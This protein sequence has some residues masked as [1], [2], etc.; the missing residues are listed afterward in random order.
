M[1]EG[2]WE[3]KG[4]REWD[5]GAGERVYEEMV[6]GNGMHKWRDDEGGVKRRRWLEEWEKLAENGKVREEGRLIVGVGYR[7]D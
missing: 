7:S 6:K 4:A 2:G 3:D 5:V 1:D